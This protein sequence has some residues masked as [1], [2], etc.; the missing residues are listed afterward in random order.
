MWGRC[1][2]ERCCQKAPFC[3]S[4]RHSYGGMN[5]NPAVAVQALCCY[6]H[7]DEGN[8]EQRRKQR[9]SVLSV[10]LRFKN[11]PRQSTANPGRIETQ[12][13]GGNRESPC[14]QCL[15]VSKTNRRSSRTV[16]TPPTTE[17]Q[18][19]GGNRES[20]CSLCLCVSKTN[21]HTPHPVAAPSIRGDQ[22]ILTEYQEDAC[23]ADCTTS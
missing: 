4:T 11:R 15:C 7:K 3:T 5:H 22:E 13:K 17:T 21:R 1:V 8:T 16:A 14:S 9:I 18:S 23:N 10:P 20:P 6:R 12:R 19:K 2:V